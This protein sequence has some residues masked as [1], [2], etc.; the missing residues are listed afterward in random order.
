MDLLLKQR[1]L[2]EAAIP[3]PMSTASPHVWKFSD[4]GFSIDGACDT[5]KRINELGGNGG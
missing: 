2:F 4:P 1:N 5:H 3:G